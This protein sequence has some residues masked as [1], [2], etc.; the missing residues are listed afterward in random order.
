[1]SRRGKIARLPEEIREELNRRLADGE[2]GSSLARWLNGLPAVREMLER[3]FGGR[4]I[5]EPNLCAWRTG[6]F[7][8]LRLRED[9]LHSANDFAANAND[10]TQA[11]DGRIT[12]HL[13]TNLAA[14]YAALLNR[15]NGD[16]DQAFERKV[17]VLHGLTRHITNMRRCDQIDARSKLTYERK[18][19]S[20]DPVQS[21][22]NLK[23]SAK[24]PEIR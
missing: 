12:D 1:M 23:T 19:R 4:D 7:A 10:L 13:S 6:G 15:W 20:D 3:Y 18:S 16:A 24:I 2:P 8:E 9:I 5:N 17:R 22:V 14:R 21:P 11:I